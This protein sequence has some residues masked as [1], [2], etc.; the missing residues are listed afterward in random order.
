MLH[1]T[2]YPAPRHTPP[3]HAELRLPA[4]CC[5]QG[6]HLSLV[7]AVKLARAQANR[8]EAMNKLTLSCTLED[9]WVLE[10]ANVQLDAEC[11]DVE[12][13]SDEEEAK[14]PKPPGA[15]AKRRSTRSRSRPALPNPAP[16]QSVNQSVLTKVIAR[17]VK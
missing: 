11:P 10:A 4:G 15:R 7:E 8:A 16:R 2:P 17:G 9:K 13:V 5:G 6:R 3:R 14:R 1:V 12:V